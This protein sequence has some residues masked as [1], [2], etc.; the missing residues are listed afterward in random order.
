[1]MI[2]INNNNN[3]NNDNNNNNINNNINNKTL[4]TAEKQQLQKCPII[5]I[6][7]H[8]SVEMFNFLLN[9]EHGKPIMVNII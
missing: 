2:I 5:K 9:E 6:I 3:N 7:S 1:M 8:K 4:K